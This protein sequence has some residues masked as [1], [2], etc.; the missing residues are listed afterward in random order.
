MRP[1]MHTDRPLAKSLEERILCNVHRLE[2]APNRLERHPAPISP[3]PR[4]LLGKAVRSRAVHLDAETLDT[5]DPKAT[6]HFDLLERARSNNR[7]RDIAADH[8]SN[9]DRDIQRTFAANK[10]PR[11]A[12][13]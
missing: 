8:R 4:K 13:V 9:S 5:I 1:E 6:K 10:T 11:L 7:W 12:H 3:Y 2:Q